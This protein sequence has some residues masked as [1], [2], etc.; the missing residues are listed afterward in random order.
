MPN[1]QGTCSDCHAGENP[2]IVHPEKAPFIGLSN[3]IASTGWHQ[4]LVDASWPQ[5]P[6]PTNLLDAVTST[7]TC[8]GCH[9]SGSAGRFPELSTELRGY[10]SAVLSSAVRETMPPG[11]E[12]RWL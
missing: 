5:N 3:S 4:P 8:D 7:R 2:Y 12:D 10:C 1:G 11:E 6:G 9:T